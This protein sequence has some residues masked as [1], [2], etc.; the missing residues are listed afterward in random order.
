MV[1]SSATEDEYVSFSAEYK[2]R[3]EERV[4]KQIALEEV[5]ESALASGIPSLYG[6]VG[7]FSEEERTRQSFLVLIVLVEREK[8][9]LQMDLRLHS[10]SGIVTD[11]GD[12][13]TIASSITSMIRFPPTA[14]SIP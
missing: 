5:D 7:G 1:L 12:R 6:D 9:D 4:A 14:P 8:R 13:R 2:Q 11:D 10:D 3:Y